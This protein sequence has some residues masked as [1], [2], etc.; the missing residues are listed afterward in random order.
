MLLITYSVCVDC[1]C[2]FSGGCFLWTILFLS[3]RI[4][5]THIS[6]YEH[7]CLLGYNAVQFV[8]SEPAFR[9]NISPPFSGSNKTDKKPV[10]NSSTCC[11]LHTAFLLTLFFDPDDG[12]NMI[13]Y[14][15]ELF[16]FPIIVPFI[17]HC[18]LYPLY[19]FKYSS[20]TSH[21]CRPALYWTFWVELLLRATVFLCTVNFPPGV[22][23]LRQKCKARA[24]P[25]K[26][27]LC[28]SIPH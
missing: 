9:G 13:S 28:P 23:G 22:T 2:S 16:S 18:I 19:T 21:S 8:E 26:S 20:I 27:D 6:S 24:L 10:G 5:G 4:W 11:L 25:Q 12:D 17:F 1:E 7:F 15:M 3:Y 14:K